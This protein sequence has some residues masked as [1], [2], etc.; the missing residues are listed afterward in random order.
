MK[1]NISMKDIARIAKVSRTTVSFVL[2]NRT[3]MKISEATRKKVLDIARK[4]DYYPNAIAKSLVKRETKTIGFFLGQD[5]RSVLSDV[6]VPQVLLGI[7]KVALKKDYKMLLQYIEDSNNKSSYYHMVREKRIEG[8]ILSSP[9][10]DDEEL[11]KLKEEGFPIVLIGQAEKKSFSCSDIDN[12]EAARKIVSHLISH[13]HKRIAMVTNAPLNYTASKLRLLGYRKALEEGN[14]DFNDELVAIGNFTPKSGFD[15]MKKL[16]SLK[17]IPTAV[18]V[19]SDVIAFGAMDYIKRK[20]MKIPDDMALVGFDNT[21]LSGYVDPPL[22]TIN[23][24]GF[25]IGVNAASLLIDIMEDGNK[26]NKKIILDA[27]MIIR[28]SCGCNL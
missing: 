9:R 23:L 21:S 20:G 13:G 28:R 18:F 24:P 19:A 2:N 5:L 22:T 10:S 15:V 6:L 26:S 27:D 4:L 7:N 1:K 16:L 14:I 12:T 3:E 17:K 8:I 11:I 25:D